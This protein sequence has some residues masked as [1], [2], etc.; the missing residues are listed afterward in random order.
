MEFFFCK[1]NIIGVHTFIL[2][3]YFQMPEQIIVFC[4]MAPT[5]YEQ[6]ML[7]CKEINT[8]QILQ[9]GSFTSAMLRP[10]NLIEISV[11]SALPLRKGREI[12]QSC[13]ILLAFRSKVP[14]EMALLKRP[15]AYSFGLYP[16]GP[17]CYKLCHF[18][19]FNVS[20]S[21][22]HAIMYPLTSQNQSKLRGSASWPS[23][24]RHS[25]RFF[26]RC[27]CF[28]VE[29]HRF[30]KT[31]RCSGLRWIQTVGSSSS[32]SSRSTKEDVLTRRDWDGLFNKSDQVKINQVFP[33]NFCFHFKMV[34]FRKES[35]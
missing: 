12:V 30:P 29:S 26:H 24:P 2:G 27:R 13:Q 5:G 16:K 8:G 28:E 23:V 9:I 22:R 10:A 18:E 32:K 25:C 17:T 4:V 21:C 33:K 11:I 6:N 19:C 35:N 34:M 1:K 15:P 20:S 31:A 3:M 14:T 7:S